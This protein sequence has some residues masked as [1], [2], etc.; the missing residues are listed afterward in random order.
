MLLDPSKLLVG[1]EAGPFRRRYVASLYAVVLNKLLVGSEVVP[2]RR[3]GVA[4]LYAVAARIKNPQTELGY[5]TPIVRGS[6]QNTNCCY[7]IVT[8]ISNARF[9]N[10][11]KITRGVS[12]AELWGTSCASINVLS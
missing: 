5:G 12:W 4:F 9:Y 10:A 1:S 2:F 3:L 7:V 8:R 11:G 6:A